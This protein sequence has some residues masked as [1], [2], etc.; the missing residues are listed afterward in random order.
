MRACERS[1]A[2]AQTW[3]EV[4]LGLNFEFLRDSDAL[5]RGNR[6]RL[7][8]RGGVELQ[9]WLSDAR[10]CAVVG[11]PAVRHAQGGISRRHLIPKAYRW[12]LLAAGVV[13][14]GWGILEPGEVSV[15][16]TTL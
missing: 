13:L 15:L 14:L 10:W 6:L 5:T 11:R 1:P 9:S 8:L 12:A 3:R 4:G 16:A 2:H 7:I